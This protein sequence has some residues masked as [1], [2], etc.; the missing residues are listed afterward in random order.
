MTK[1]KMQ[2]DPRLTD[3]ISPA[4]QRFFARLPEH[5]TLDTP[6]WGVVHILGYFCARYKKHYGID[7]TFRFNNPAPSK[8]YEIFRIKSLAQMLSSDPT[9]L[10]DYIDW[11]FET[12]VIARK[13]RIT[14]LGFITNVELVNKYKF[15]RLLP[16]RTIDRA[17]PLPPNYWQVIQNHGS[18]HT[19]NIKTYGD[20]VFFKMGLN[21]FSE[22]KDIELF[23][24]LK[25]AGMS[26]EMLGKVK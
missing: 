6:K 8:S 12:E 13:K 19:K 21:E 1:K 10:K 9:I 4:Y 25:K 18:I 11:L 5:A 20:L 15:E 22:P 16:G 24:E 17:T 14:A 3:P 7:Y 23:K 26:M 2:A